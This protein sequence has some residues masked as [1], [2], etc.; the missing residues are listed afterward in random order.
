MVYFRGKMQQKLFSRKK[1][2]Y[3]TFPLWDFITEL[4][5]ATDVIILYIQV[6]KKKKCT[7]IKVQCQISW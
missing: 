2:T 1:K 7:Y 5:L 4:Y 6:L 3:L